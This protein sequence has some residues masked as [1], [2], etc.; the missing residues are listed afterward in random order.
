MT[1]TVIDN[2]ISS[3]RVL[4]N[5]TLSHLKSCLSGFPQGQTQLFPLNLKHPFISCR[6]CALVFITTSVIYAQSCTFFF[7]CFLHKMDGRVFL[8]RVLLKQ[9]F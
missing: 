8:A 4:K 6:P 7:C 9:D 3:E 2:W 1:F 5:K